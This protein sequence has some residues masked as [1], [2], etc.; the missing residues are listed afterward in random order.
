MTA[1]QTLDTRPVVAATAGLVPGVTAPLCVGTAV[2]ALPVNASVTEFLA[3]HIDDEMDADLC[4]MDVDHFL[5]H[6]PD[7]ACASVEGLLG[8]DW[9]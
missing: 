3:A 1:N 9:A 8:D 5:S 4:G 6:N 7:L 2:Q